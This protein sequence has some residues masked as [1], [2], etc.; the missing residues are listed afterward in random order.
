MALTEIKFGITKVDATHADFNSTLQGL[1]I[2]AVISGATV[3]YSGGDVTY[4]V[5][6]SNIAMA[7][8]QAIVSL[9]AEVSNYPF[10]IKVVKANTVPAGVPNRDYTDD[11]GA[12]AVH[13]WESWK[14]S[15][16]DFAT[17]DNGDIYVA[18]EAHDGKVTKLNDFSTVFA[19]CVDAATYTSLLPSD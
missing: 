8:A 17:M 18:S 9:G 10:F 7:T 13:T 12:A 15:A 11:Q 5:E 6:S 16:F 2:Q 3:K 4:F 19:D 14:A 1:A